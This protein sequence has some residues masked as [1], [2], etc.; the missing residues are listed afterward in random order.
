MVIQTED[1]KRWKIINLTGIDNRDVLRY[2][3]AVA[4]VRKWIELE[5]LRTESKLRGSAIWASSSSLVAGFRIGN[6][7]QG[8]DCNRFLFRWQEHLKESGRQAMAILYHTS[9]FHGVIGQ[10]LRHTKYESR[11]TS[12]LFLYARRPESLRGASVMKK[13]FSPED[14]P[15]HT[16]SPYAVLD[17]WLQGSGCRA[18]LNVQDWPEDSRYETLRRRDRVLEFVKDVMPSVPLVNEKRQMR[19]SRYT[20]E[21]E[22]LKM[23]TK[24]TVNAYLSNR[25]AGYVVNGVLNRQRRRNKREEELRARKGSTASESFCIGM[26]RAVASNKDV[27]NTMLKSLSDMFEDFVSRVP[28]EFI[29]QPEQQE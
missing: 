21:A 5:R 25:R 16:I 3:D 2:F 27:E 14:R 19:A 26:E 11:S 9:N 12:P 20:F 10:G 13:I 29:I 8:H 28:E 15:I 22:T 24:N 7:W 18:S 4:T 6:V 1:L 17:T 23:A